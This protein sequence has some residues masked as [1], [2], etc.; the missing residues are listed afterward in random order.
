M[1]PHINY[2]N[3]KKYII[4]ELCNN[5]HGNET[6]MDKTIILDTSFTYTLSVFVHIEYEETCTRDEYFYSRKPSLPEITYYDFDILLYNEDE[7]KYLEFPFYDKLKNDI[8]NEYNNL[9]NA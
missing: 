5:N 8:Y 3:L 4:N 9:I 1:T 2:E 6:T 7:E